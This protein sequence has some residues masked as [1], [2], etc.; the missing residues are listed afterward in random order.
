MRTL[1]WHELE[2][3][4]D[5]A[6]SEFGD[7]A[8]IKTG[9]PRKISTNQ[10]GVAKISLYTPD[11]RLLTRSVALLVARAFVRPDDREAFD[12]PIH[13]DGDQAN[14]RADN[15]VWRPRWF[16]IKYHKQF[17]QEEFYAAKAVFMD[18]DTEEVYESVQE[19]CI[20]HGLYWHDVVR[21][22]VEETFCFPTWQHFRLLEQ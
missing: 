19:A 21:S 11:G 13:L 22:F 16:A 1:R 9:L 18:R 14:C 7:I 8:N 12:T 6:V 4:P 3:F 10:F 15:L 2:E 20:K 5:Y 17:R